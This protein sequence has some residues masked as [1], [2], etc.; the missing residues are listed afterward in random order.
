MDNMYDPN[1]EKTYNL[2]GAHLM[3]KRLVNRYKWS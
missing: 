3:T 2:I 1:R